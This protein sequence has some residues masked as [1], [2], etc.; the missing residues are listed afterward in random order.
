[1]KKQIAAAFV[2]LFALSVE[3]QADAVRIMAAFTFKN[4]RSMQ[5]YSLTR[6]TAAGMSCC[7]TA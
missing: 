5:L 1:M 6:L 3:A 2:L 7:F 4:A